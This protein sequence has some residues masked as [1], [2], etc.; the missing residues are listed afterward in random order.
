MCVYVCVWGGACVVGLESAREISGD[1]ERRKGLGRE[2]L[3][4]DGRGIGWRED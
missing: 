4:G 2:E 3:E 1:I